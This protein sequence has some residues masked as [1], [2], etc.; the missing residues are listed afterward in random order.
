MALMVMELIK[1]YKCTVCGYITFIKHRE[2]PMCSFGKDL[3]DGVRTEN[4]HEEKPKKD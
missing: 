2:C 4:G 1:R 3:L